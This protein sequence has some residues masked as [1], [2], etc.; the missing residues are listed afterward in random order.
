MELLKGLLI[1]LLFILILVLLGNMFLFSKNRI[2]TRAH[3]FLSA[4]VLII[5]CIFLS[6]PI[7]EGFYYDLRFIPFL[8]AGL[9]GGR[10]VTLGLAVLVIFARFTLGGDGFW[11]TLILVVLA[12]IFII[13]LSP[14]FL[15]KPL[16]VKLALVTAFSFCYSVLGFLIPSFIYGFKDY[17]QFAIYALVLVGSTFFVSYLIEI[18]R[19]SFVLQLEA[20]K[21]EKM[22]IVS[23]LAA[24]ISHE[25]RNPLTSVKGFLQ[26]IAENENTP[27]D[28]KQYATY[29]LEEAGRA[30]E[31]IDDYLTFAKPHSVVE[32]SININQEVEK[33]A[34]ILRPFA[35]KHSVD[36][37]ILFLHSAQIKGDPHKFQQVLMNIGKNA[38]EA[39]PEGGNLTILSTEGN[40]KVNIHITDTGI[41]MKPEHVARLGEPYFS[42]KGQKGTGLGLMVVYKIVESMSGTVKVVSE[43]NTGTSVTL[44]FPIHTT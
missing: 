5:L 6:V 24:S 33:C 38:I 26:L 35:L 22:E 37:D 11:I 40:G 20:I 14:R 32:T 36:V 41:G 19:S 43:L 7:R 12:T 9:Y 23:H 1:N 21:F 27:S 15:Q 31:I 25:V 13:F 44:S 10:R 34:E 8:L 16:R 18:L 3:L 2:F 4:A 29:A 28:S 39:M 30:S 42:L 17:I